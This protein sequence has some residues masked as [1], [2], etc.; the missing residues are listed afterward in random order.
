[1]SRFLRVGFWAAAIAAFVM[2]VL[3][4]PPEL[5]G[6]PLDKLQHIVAFAAL[7]LLE[8]AAY[9]STSLVR[10]GVALSVFG[11]PIELVQA[12]RALHRDS[13]AIDWVVD[14]ASA[15]FV[16]VLVFLWRSRSR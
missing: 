14:T 2:A 15:T 10:L 8:S 16:L 1:M 11:A 3:P 5:P 6:A 7:A 4:Q 9:P 13:D 12:I